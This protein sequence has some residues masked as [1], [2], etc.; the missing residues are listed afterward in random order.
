MIKKKISFEFYDEVYLC[1][2]LIQIGDINSY[3]KRMKKTYPENDFDHPIYD[4]ENAVTTYLIS[5]VNVISIYFPRF[6]PDSFSI[7]TLFH[8]ITHCALFIF[9]NNKIEVNDGYSEPFCYYVSYLAKKF[10]E[11]IKKRKKQKHIV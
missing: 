7:G 6:K 11:L 1:K 10:L 9:G 3:L 8:E 5:D 4:G 2:Y